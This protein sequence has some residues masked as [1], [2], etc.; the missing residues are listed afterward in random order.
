MTRRN[1]RQ[2]PGKHSLGEVAKIPP[3]NSVARLLFEI[4]FYGI[5]ALPGGAWANPYNC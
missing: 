3:A 1:T 4:G 2:D 5:M